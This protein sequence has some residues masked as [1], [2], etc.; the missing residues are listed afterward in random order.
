VAQALPG[1]IE[2][3]QALTPLLVLVAQNMSSQ[4]AMW[5]AFFDLLSGDKSIASVTTSLTG[6][7]GPLGD[8]FRGAYS[9]GEAFGGALNTVAT[10]ADVLATVVRSKIDE[11]VG[12]VASVPSRILS[13]FAGAGDWLVSSGRALIGG[14]VD[15]IR[16]SVGAVGD[17]VNDVLSWAAGF[18]PHSPAKRGIFSGSGWSDLP[19]SGAALLEQWSSGF[20]EGVSAPFSLTSLTRVSPVPSSTVAGASR[21]RGRQ[22]RDVVV[23]ALPGMTPQEQAEL[24]AKEL[25]WA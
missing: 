18:F 7:V 23:Q 11:T 15:G 6:L 12:V 25:R 3:I 9:M 24:I 13:V 19:K 8:V 2:L 1:V 14:F 4:P 16:A 17:A 5:S 21:E 22:F 10:S 20:P